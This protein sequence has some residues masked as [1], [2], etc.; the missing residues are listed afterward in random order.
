MRL[1]LSFALLQALLFRS[2]NAFTAIH[3]SFSSPSTATKLNVL[4]TTLL[5]VDP[6]DPYAKLLEAYAKKGSPVVEASSSAAVVTTAP[7]PPP[8]EALVQAGQTTDFTE[9]ATKALSDA[10][11]NALQVMS[12]AAAQAASSAAEAASQAAAAAASISVPAITTKAG[13]AAATTVKAG[14]APTLAQ[15]LASGQYLRVTDETTNFQ[16]AQQ[17]FAK[18]ADN[19]STQLD[20][21]N[22]VIAPAVKATTSSAVT[23]KTSATAA[24][25][26]AGL[27]ASSLD[28]QAL[29][30]QL[31][32][33]EYG[34]WYV[35]G[36]SVLV[37]AGQRQAGMD[38]AKQKYEGEIALA[39]AR[40]DEA[41]EAAAVAAKGAQVAKELAT[42]ISGDASSDSVGDTLLERSKLQEMMVEKEMMREEVNRLTD[43]TIRMGKQIE[44]LL[45]EK[46]PKKELTETVVATTAP[47]KVSKSTERDP[48]EDARIISILKEIDESNKAAAAV[49]V[50]AAVEASA[51]AE[52]ADK[53][54][55]EAEAVARAAAVAVAEIDEA[56][57]AATEALESEEEIRAISEAA[58]EKKAVE[59]AAKKAAKKAVNNVTAKAKKTKTKKTTKKK[60]TRVVRRKT[61][62]TP[63]EAVV[64]S[65]Q[66]ENPWAS[67]TEA[68][69]KRKTVAQL[70]EYLSERGVKVI[71]ESSG[72]TL[73]KALLV[74]SVQSL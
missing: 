12:D 68:T 17:G 47:A 3:P 72:K 51:A 43:E 8:V 16:N 32:L 33:Q 56:E 9:T 22:K 10:S 6:D 61:V 18:L 37:A 66:A 30:D 31:N 40:A 45:K 38:A 14:A 64:V 7:P 20:S 69:L 42:K 4:P 58:A 35:A 21:A 27:G 63:K 59:E 5:A 28:V 57:E 50:A 29:I 52:A 1:Q 34:P 60:T 36:I 65:S 49:D 26:A 73:K 71:D 15:Y 74:E 46:E 62:A 55:E 23:V 24:A 13:V 25:G 41:A 54:A 44:M 39:R 48:E 67:L 2:S 70:T 19:F 53:F 11:G